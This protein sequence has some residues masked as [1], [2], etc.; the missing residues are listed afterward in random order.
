L[1]MPFSVAVQSSLSWPDL[2]RETI[3]L[4]LQRI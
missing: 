2:S 3:Y 4:I 1:L